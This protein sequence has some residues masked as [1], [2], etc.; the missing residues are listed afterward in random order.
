[1][2]RGL[3]SVWRKLTW[4]WRR[5]PKTVG[6]ATG[7][8]ALL[9]LVIAGSNAY[10]LLTTSGEAIPVAEPVELITANVQG[11]FSVSQNGMLAYFS[12]GAG[13]HSTLTWFDRGGKSAGKVA[14]GDVGDRRVEHLHEGGHDHDQRDNPGI[15]RLEARR[16]IWDGNRTHDFPPFVVGAVAGLGAV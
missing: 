5:F 13:L 11:S 2:K 6:G 3:L 12:A 16:G 15:D 14:Q 7:L 9:C 10:I 4:P 8:F 1:M